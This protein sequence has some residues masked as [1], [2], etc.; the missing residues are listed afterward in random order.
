MKNMKKVIISIFL[1]MI[2]LGLDGN[3]SSPAMAATKTTATVTATPS[4]T[5]VTVN[6]KAKTFEAYTMNGEDY[7][8]LIDLAYVLKKTRCE[9]GFWEDERYDAVIINRESDASIYIQ[10]FKTAMA[11]G[12]GK[13]KSAKL[14]ERN[15]YFN[16]ILYHPT[17]YRING[18]DYYKLTELMD[19]LNCGVIKNK[20]TG[21]VNF[22]TSKYYEPEFPAITE[23]SAYY[24][25][26]QKELYDAY[27]KYEG[28]NLREL[29]MMPL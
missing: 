17:V 24:K 9:F 4:K 6:K 14:V 18:T 7:Y 5:K 23:G 15:V 28:V 22:D 13:K 21:A 3:L 20:K 25:K 10:S 29:R 11:K 12:D 8:K 1:L 19:L 2:L 26:I 16:K 27:F